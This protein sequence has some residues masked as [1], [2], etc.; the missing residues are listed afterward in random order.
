MDSVFYKLLLFSFF[1]YKFFFID[2]LAYKFRLIDFFL[3]RFLMIDF[4]LYRLIVIDILFYRFIVF[5]RY[6][7]R[8][9]IVSERLD[10]ERIERVLERS[11]FMEKLELEYFRVFNKFREFVKLEMELE[12]KR[13]ERLVRE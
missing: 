9:L 10:L 8:F 12:I 4:F 3:Y 5:E 1:L 13:R 6:G 11:R 2:F 7:L